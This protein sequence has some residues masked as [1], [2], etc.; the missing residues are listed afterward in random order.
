MK[1]HVIKNI[2][3]PGIAA[4]LEIE[5]GDV[6]LAVNG[7]TVADVFDY[8]YQIQDEYIEIKIKKK[9]G[10]IFIY[11]IE[12][13]ALEGLG[14][15]FNSY[16]MDNIRRCNNKCVFCFVDQLPGNMRESLYF[17]D[18]DPRLSFLYGNYVTLTN[19]SAREL[20]RLISY[21]MSP[22]NISVHSTDPALRSYLLGN[23]KAGLVMEKIKK[24]AEAGLMMN[25]Q[26]VLCKG[27]NDGEALDKSIV[28]LAAFYPEGNSLSVVPAGLSAHRQGLH[29][30]ETFNREEA[31]EVIT[32]IHGWQKKLAPRLKNTF[33]FAADEFY[34]KA[35][36]DIPGYDK[37]E[38]FPQ[39]ENGVGMM[40]L[41]EHE[42]KLSLKKTRGSGKSK[43]TEIVTGEAAYGYMKALTGVISGYFPRCAIKVHKIIN[44]FFGNSITVSGL[45]TGKDIF[46]SLKGKLSGETLLIP[47]NALRA[48]T[49]YF[50]DDV[51]VHSLSESLGIRVIPCEISGE[52]FIKNLAV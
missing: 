4:E 17:K 43:I 6:L 26:I 21:R 18:D 32:Q 46:E 12:K 33:L 38:G 2:I 37:Y 13:D 10:E 47:K 5:P 22:I 30:I 9:S 11:E 1:N 45:L 29:R 19:I 28:D 34:I 49:D 8:N 24:I 39:L 44:R 36:R 35:G 48:G 3:E 41:F 7:K 27:I 52:A 40:A 14:I 16:L 25:F 51:D 31:C 42:V 23:K 15:E 50:L 20:N